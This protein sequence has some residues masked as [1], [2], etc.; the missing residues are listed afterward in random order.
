MQSLPLFNQNNFQFMAHLLS[1]F[2]IANYYKVEV[3]KSNTSYK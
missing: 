3:L 2:A 1:I